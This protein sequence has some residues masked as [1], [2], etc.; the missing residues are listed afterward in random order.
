V[1]AGVVAVGR[2]RGAATAT[3]FRV[4][5]AG[6]G[7]AA[8]A[9]VG[10]VDPSRHALVPPC[11]LRALTGYDCP[12]CGATRATHALLHGQLAHAADLNALYV[13]TLPLVGVLVLLWLVRGRLPAWTSRPAA[14]W[15]ATGVAM[16][17]MVLR[18]LPMAPFVSLHS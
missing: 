12:L 14:L 13:A 8:V 18:N 6:A 4:L 9:V 2:P 5:A 7:C 1:T 11:L 10:L 15:V 3:R 16:V 17:F